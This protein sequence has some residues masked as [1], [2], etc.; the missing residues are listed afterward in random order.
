MATFTTRDG[1]LNYY[2]DWGTGHPSSPDR[3][4]EAA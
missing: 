1:T 4:Q 3:L 2:K